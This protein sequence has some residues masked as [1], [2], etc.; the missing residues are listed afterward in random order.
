M[1]ATSEVLTQMIA[2]IHKNAINAIKDVVKK[3]GAVA[4]ELDDGPYYQVL[5]DQESSL[6]CGVN[7]QTE[8]ILVDQVD[9]IIQI[10]LKSVDTMLLLAVLQELENGKFDVIES[11]KDAEEV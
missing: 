3:A 1:Q 4:V 5:N 10:G 11:A 8:E 9:E 7:I 6:I 2:D